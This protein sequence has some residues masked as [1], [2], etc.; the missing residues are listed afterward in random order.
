MADQLD[1][2]SVLRG[3]VSVKPEEHDQDRAAR[4]RRE[5]RAALIEDCKGVVVFVCVLLVIGAIAALSVFKG[6]FDPSATAETQRWAQAILTAVVSGS[7]S[8]VV[9]RKVGK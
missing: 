1:L 2:Q 4:I 8:F 6:F 7:I 9:G 5:D 3:Q